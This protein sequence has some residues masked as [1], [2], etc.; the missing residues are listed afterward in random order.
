MIL[1]HWPGPGAR[2]IVTGHTGDDALENAAMG[3][4]ALAE[5]SPS[6][7]WPAGRGLM[8][9][10]PL[11]GQRRHAIRDRLAQAGWSWVDDP[12]NHNRA[13]PRI[14]ARQAMADDAVPPEPPDLAATASL[15]GLAS[16]GP[17]F[18]RFPRNVLGDADSAARRRVVAAAAVS[19]G[20][21][22]T[23]PRGDRLDSLIERLLGDQAFITTLAGARITA[24]PEVLFTR[25]AGERAR[26]GLGPVTLPSLWDGRFE[27]G[28]TGE[29]IALS[30]LT[31][32]LSRAERAALAQLPA[33]ARP[34]L[35]GVRQNGTLHCPVLAT[36]S[37][38]PV[39]EL[40][41]GRFLA[42]CGVYAQ[43]RE[44]ELWLR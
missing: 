26:G 39:R 38:N 33:P 36:D 43:E 25:E 27:I 30:G 11:L 16:F 7:V 24:G 4:G 22:A 13:H 21:G 41:P 2:V 3:Q 29:A 8:L 10:R 5:W 34:G 31:T 18:I 44:L 42:A 35:P 17:G 40:V 12:A 15:A 9:L 1:S 14:Q 6:P 28:G 19:G 32:Q 20:G 23:P 37:Q